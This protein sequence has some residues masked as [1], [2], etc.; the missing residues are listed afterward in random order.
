MANS[1][2][3]SVAAAIHTKLV[4]DS[5]LVTLTGHTVSKPK[6]FRVY[7]DLNRPKKSL[8]FELVNATPITSNCTHL[9]KFTVDFVSF[10]SEEKDSIDIVDRVSYLLHDPTGG[11]VGYWDFSDSNI[12]VHNSQYVTRLGSMYL[13]KLEL[14]FH[15]VRMSALVD[16]YTP[17]S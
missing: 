14:Y 2:W 7:P 4:S 12:R 13:P 6:I 17:C 9:L 1:E 11:N 16:P 5:T 8:A 3:F 15:G 10:C